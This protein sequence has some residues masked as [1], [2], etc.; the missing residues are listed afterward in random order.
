MKTGVLVKPKSDGTAR[1]WPLL[2]PRVTVGRAMTHDVVLADAS[3]SRDH[4]VIE[5]QYGA[6]M[7]TDRDSRNGTRV[8]GVAVV[9]R[10]LNDGDLIA[11]GDVTMVFHVVDDE[12]EAAPAAA[13]SRVG[14]QPALRTIA[15]PDAVADSAAWPGVYAWQLLKALSNIQTRPL[16]DYVRLAISDLSG[17]RHVTGSGVGLMTEAGGGWKWIWHEGA[18]GSIKLFSAS[19]E[20]ADEVRAGRAVY[21]ARGQ[22]TGAEDEADGAVFPISTC[23]RVIGCLCV[24]GRSV[25]PPALLAIFRAASEAFGTALGLRE[26]LTHRLAEQGGGGVSR[27][28]APVIVGRSAVLMQ[29][30]RQAVKAARHEATVLI[31]GETGTG[32][33]LFARLIVDESPRRDKPYIPVHCSAIDENLLGSMLFGHEKG[34]FTGAVGMK[35]GVFEE[36]D[37]GTIFLDEI[38][39]LSP[40]MQVKL[41]RVLQE[42]EFMRLGGTKPLRVNVRIIAATNRN[43]EK[44][45]RDGQFRE[46]LFYRLNVIAL[47]LPPLRER[48]EDIPELVRHYVE[49][50]SR[51]TARGAMTVSPEAMARLQGYDWPGNI[52]ELRNVVERGL[53]LA[54]NGV[55]TEDD[56]PP[57]VARRESAPAAPAEGQSL[58][59][60]EREHILAVLRECGGNKRLAAERLAISRSTL[61]EKLKDGPR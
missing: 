28:A 26:A 12:P 23:G 22:R 51:E 35:K 25:F 59:K 34:A 43:L 54:E 47:T 19:D 45:I 32:K 60:M 53:V 21:R 29:V 6:W 52:R 50:L 61:Y 38:G 37:G 14:L 48:R 5:T 4:A 46:D 8:N 18:D 11:F 56:L 40:V 33:E 10:H 57:E 2:K 58:E 9:S 44:G 1:P 30:M 17:I 20:V 36:A 15:A 27:R 16:D 3:V 24:Q 13:E 39:E 49:G 55:I 42:G 31:R 7:L 41:L